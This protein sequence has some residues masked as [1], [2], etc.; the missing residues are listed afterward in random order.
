MIDAARAFD[1]LGPV[2]SRHPVANGKRCV[3][4][5]WALG[6]GVPVGWL[7]L[8]GATAVGDDATVLAHRA[9]GVL[10][11][12]G[13]AGLYIA[14]TQALRVVRG[15]SAEYFEVRERGLVHGSR[16]GP[17]VF[18]WDRVT[19]ITIR[20]AQRDNRLARQL[21]TGYRCVLR[22]ADGRRVRVD[23]LAEQ[24]GT[25]GLA[26]LG[27]CP[28]AL[29]LTGDEWWQKAGG[30]L[31]AA[32]AACF[33]AVIAMIVFIVG[34]PDKEITDPNDIANVRDIPGLGG[35]QVVL[36]AVGILVCLIAGVT[37]IVLSVQA[38]RMRR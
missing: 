14:V 26:V 29:R 5:F 34:H 35:T 28:H 23:G 7:G 32:G 13:L 15:G 1:E 8:W 21:G 27:R 3:N 36:L 10:I 2:V 12:L 33:A 22:L 20:T 9:V 18:A 11:G 6:I 19:A 38:R 4:A 30:W 24:H 17:T 16:R 25:L 31:P 37:C